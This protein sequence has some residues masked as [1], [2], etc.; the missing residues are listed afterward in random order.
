MLTAMT[1]KTT[2][3]NDINIH[4]LTYFKKKLS[5]ITKKKYIYISISEAC[6]SNFFFANSVFIRSEHPPKI[7]KRNKVHILKKHPV[8]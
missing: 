2:N 4:I 5:G 8:S 6:C 3:L 7:R 1:E